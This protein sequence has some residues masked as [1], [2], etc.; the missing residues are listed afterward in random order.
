MIDEYYPVYG[1]ESEQQYE[2][3]SRDKL[4]LKLEREQSYFMYGDFNS[5]LDKAELTAYQ[6]N[7]TGAQLHLESK[8]A[9]VDAFFSRNDQILIKGL[10]IP[11]RGV[12]GYY[13]LPDKDITWNSERIVMDPRPLTSGSGIKEHDPSRL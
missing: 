6:R 10:E 12:S 2:A 4:Y 5:K 1:D 7:M 13:T 11:G 9:D 8:Y 3:E